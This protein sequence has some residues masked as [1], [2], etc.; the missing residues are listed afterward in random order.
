MNSRSKRPNS[1][2][3]P[4][5]LLHRSS[6]RARLLEAAERI[7]AERGYYATSIRDIARDAGFSVGGVYQFVG[8]KSE[9]Y[10]AVIE[11]QWT[12]LS[13]AVAEALGQDGCI[14]QLRALTG[15]LLE[16][17]EAR[18]DFVRVHMSSLPRFPAPFKR[19][20]A[21][22][23]SRRR[24]RFRGQVRELMR[25]GVETSVL[26]PLDAELLTSAYLGLL[27][28]SAFDTLTASSPARRPAA[29]ADSLLSLFLNGAAL[30]GSHLC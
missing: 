14:R 8:G 17:L 24:R 30:P 7:F 11:A 5:R 15:R 18:Q 26:R 28:I 22:R 23:L 2:L 13:A 4:R 29:A 25:R 20:I 19:E 1:R 10:L 21:N 3:P 6:D 9:L 12:S 27:Y 16:Y